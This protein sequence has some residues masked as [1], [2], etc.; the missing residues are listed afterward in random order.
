MEENKNTASVPA[1]PVGS[2]GSP[3]PVYPEPVRKQRRVGTFTLGLSLILLGVL[4]P[5]GLVFGMQAWNLLRFAPVVLIF[6]GTEVLYYAIRYKDDK[7]RYDGLSIFMVIVITFTT[8]VGS[9]VVPPILNAVSYHRELG[10]IR[11]EINSD[12]RKEMNALGYHG[13]VYSHEFY[14]DYDWYS[15][16]DSAP[17]KEWDLSVHVRFSTDDTAP[18]YTKEEF[19]KACVA[20]LPVLQK[21]KNIYEAYFQY[22]AEVEDGLEDYTLELFDTDFS[23]ADV[24]GV[25]EMI[26]AEHTPYDTGE[27]TEY[28]D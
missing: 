17:P 28:S 12:V 19:A 13:T 1:S 21:N 6:L 24:S 27:N 11:S 23:S 14:D 16:F 18:S 8:L 25:L 10:E 22:T 2:C 26:R 20:M 4:I 15:S 7:L 5:C 3:A 9:A